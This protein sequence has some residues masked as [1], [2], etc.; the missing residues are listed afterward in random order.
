MNQINVS[1]PGLTKP[2]TSAKSATDL[3]DMLVA[4]PEN[5]EG[6]LLRNKGS[7]IDLNALY[8]QSQHNQGFGIGVGMTMMPSAGNMTQNLGNFGLQPTPNPTVNDNK[9]FHIGSPQNSGFV[10]P[11]SNTNGTGFDGI[12]NQPNVMPTRSAP[13]PPNFNSGLSVPNSSPSMAN[14]MHS[15]GVNQMPLAMFSQT[16]QPLQQ[17]TQTSTPFN[18]PMPNMS[19]NPFQM[20]TSGASPH[21]P[22]FQNQSTF[23]PGPSSMANQSL[24]Q[25]NLSTVN[26]TP[27][28]PLAPTLGN[29][30][31]SGV[32]LTMFTAP[33]Q[34]PFSTNPNHCIATNT[35]NQL[36]IGGG[37]NINFPKSM[38]T[39]SFQ[40]NASMTEPGSVDYTLTPSSTDLQ[41][42]GTSTPANNN[43][44]QVDVSKPD[45]GMNKK[46]FVP[47][48]QFLHRN[49]QVV[50]DVI[51][52]NVG[53]VDDKGRNDTLDGFEPISI[54]NENDTPVEVKN[55]ASSNTI[56][57]SDKN[58]SGEQNSE[59]EAAEEAKESPGTQGLIYF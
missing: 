6:N 25:N 49:S 32:N 31:S 16:G 23:P 5:K 39:S 21:Q 1:T 51:D 34:D 42:L 29:S 8:Q 24:F 56:A 15:Q 20:T 55:Q 36:P 52:E 44:A 59:V 7:E 35:N 4:P 46:K 19:S 17:Q 18:T 22:T 11:T 58:D 2:I 43:V 26:S 37:L 3:A 40:T 54:P 53:Q 14:N 13:Q 10:G 9:L 12:L 33:G 57:N 38:S 30:E 28:L 27:N 45:E 50:E 48:F 47:G 41:S